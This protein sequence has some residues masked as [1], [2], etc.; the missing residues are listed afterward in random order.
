MD[1]LTDRR[2]SFVCIGNGLLLAPEQDAYDA[3]DDCMKEFAREHGGALGFPESM[4]GINEQMIAYFYASHG[5]TWTHIGSQYQIVLWKKVVNPQ[6][7]PY[8]FHYF[9]IK[10]WKMDLMAW[11]DLQVWWRFAK[12]AHEEHGN[13]KRYVAKEFQSNF[14]SIEKCMPEFCLWCK[15]HGHTFISRD[16][17]IECQH[18]LDN[19]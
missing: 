18:F 10:L 3:F 11:P 6:E 12:A 13:I 19:E 1:A 2:G 15:E 17:E 5:F 8:L 4:S 7:P 16:C 14:D 9:N